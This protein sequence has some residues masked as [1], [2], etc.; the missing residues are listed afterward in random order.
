MNNLVLDGPY[1][2]KTFY[3]LSRITNTVIC[4]IR[5]PYNS[6]E[7]TYYRSKNGFRMHSW[8]RIY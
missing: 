1:C 7:Y 3:G 8:K 6:L 4:H 5:T 2:G